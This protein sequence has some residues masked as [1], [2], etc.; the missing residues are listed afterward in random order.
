MENLNQNNQ[1]KEP[2]WP[3]IIEISTRK[4]KV[5]INP[6]DP[7]FDRPLSELNRQ[8]GDKNQKVYFKF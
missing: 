4:P 2:G 1:Q 8:Y 5:K 3:K 6:K 7:A